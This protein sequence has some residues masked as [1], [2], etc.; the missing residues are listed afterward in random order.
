[1]KSL[2]FLTEF[3]RDPNTVGAILPSSNSLA[4]RVLSGID[5]SDVRVIVE[6]GSGTGVFT[7][8]ILNRVKQGTVFL[9]FETNPGFSALLRSEFH[10]LDVVERSAV[11]LASV[12]QKKKISGVDVIISGLPFASFDAELQ[13]NIIRP[14]A[15]ALIEGGTF[16]TFAYIQGP[17]LANGR[18]FRRIVDRYFDSVTTTSVVWMNLPPAFVYVCR[19]GSKPTCCDQEAGGGGNGSGEGTRTRRP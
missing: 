10:D 1:M 19:K 16:R 5:F 4:R 17:L 6:F 3:L 9:A 11:E 13:E 18:N 7:R 2:R 15:D 8:E 14:S 12:L